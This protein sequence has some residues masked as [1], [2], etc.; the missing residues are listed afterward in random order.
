VNAPRSWPNNSLSSSSEVNA[1]QLTGAN[2]APARGLQPWTARAATSL[3]VPL[4]PSR[5]T[6][7]LVVAAL[8]ARPTTDRIAALGPST[9]W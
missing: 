3:P 2:G 9:S 1:V 7:V 5:S 6:V 4:S 8:R